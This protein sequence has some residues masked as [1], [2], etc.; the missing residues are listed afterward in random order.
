MWSRKRL[1]GYIN[2]RT[3]LASGSVCFWPLFCLKF[4]PAIILISGENSNHEFSLRKKRSREIFLIGFLSGDETNE[5]HEKKKNFIPSRSCEKFWKRSPPSKIY[6][7]FL[8]K[9]LENEEEIRFDSPW[10]EISKLNKSRSSSWRGIKLS[11]DWF[12]QGL[13]KIESEDRHEEDQLG[14]E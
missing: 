10:L 11:Q 5:V 2:P 1:E 13:S 6:L 12:V 14:G 4:V 7:R 3:S 9:F 8:E